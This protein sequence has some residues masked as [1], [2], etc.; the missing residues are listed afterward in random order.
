MGRTTLPNKK[1]SNAPEFHTVDA[2]V[3]ERRLLFLL[4][5]AC[6]EHS[7]LQK[8]VSRVERQRLSLQKSAPLKVP[9]K[10]LITAEECCGRTAVNHRLLSD[11]D[12]SANEDF[13][14]TLHFSI[15]YTSSGISI[16]HAGTG[17]LRR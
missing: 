2:A 16:V 14:S 11:L 15:V 10:R 7:R 4:G 17:F 8:G 1:K 12:V 5:E 13:C 3:T 6:K 9:K